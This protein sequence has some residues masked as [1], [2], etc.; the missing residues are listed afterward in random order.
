MR[1][2]LSFVLVS[3][4]LFGLTQSAN[5][6]EPKRDVPPARRLAQLGGRSSPKA[7]E[8]ALADPDVEL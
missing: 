6:D 2:F 5:A 7:L 3:L 4:A 1:P 8:L